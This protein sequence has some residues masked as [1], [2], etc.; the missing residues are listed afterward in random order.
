M[1]ELETRLAEGRETLAKARAELEAGEAAYAAGAAAYE[2]RSAEG[3]AQLEEARLTLEENK[4]A[5]TAKY[6]E[7]YDQL[8]EARL[9]LLDKQ[10]QL[11]QLKAPVWYIFTR[12]D[13]PNYSDFLEDSLRIDAIAS[14][15]PIFFVLVVSLVV[16]TTMTRMVDE[17]RT[18]VGTYKALGYPPAVTASDSSFTRCLPGS[19]AVYWGCS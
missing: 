2:T 3:R 19:S 13:N 14:V 7:T 12:E 8:E 1:E 16:L 17:S 5:F 6:N 15:F 11:A 10:E 4:A 18:L 9:T